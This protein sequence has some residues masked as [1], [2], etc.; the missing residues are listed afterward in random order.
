[1]NAK[2][3]QVHSNW[4]INHT[5]AAD[6]VVKFFSEHWWCSK[7]IKLIASNPKWGLELKA[8]EVSELSGFSIYFRKYDEKLK[9]EWIHSSS[10]SLSLSL[11]FSSSLSLTNS[12]FLSPNSVHLPYA[13]AAL[14]C[15]TRHV[16]CEHPTV[17]DVV[18]VASL[19]RRRK[20]NG[21]NGCASCTQHTHC[22]S[23]TWCYH[24]LH[25]PS[26]T[27]VAERMKR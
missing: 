13:A 14:R 12:L 19:L 5:Q 22:H 9:G 24:H 1:M 2:F 23:Y 27:L 4:Q 7:Q 15:Q 17:I 6:V 20:I 25:V 3:N 26:T 21:I 16:F 11:F 18:L 8:T 10:L